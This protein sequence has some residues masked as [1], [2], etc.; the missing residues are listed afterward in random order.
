MSFVSQY[1]GILQEKRGIL[2]VCFTFLEGDEEKMYAECIHLDSNML[3]EFRHICK[4]L[5]IFGNVK[6]RKP[7]KKNKK[8][9]VKKE[10]KKSEVKKEIKK[11]EVKK[12][13]AE[14]DFREI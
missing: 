1:S 11:S 10:I 12:E 8:P 5:T 9:E 6:K 3:K 4:C 13:D 7:P 14:A 2:T